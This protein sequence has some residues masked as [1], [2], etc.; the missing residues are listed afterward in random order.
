MRDAEKAAATVSLRA[1]LLAD[2]AGGD[3]GDPAD[4][5]SVS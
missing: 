5:R 3:T 4:L 1:I 2:E